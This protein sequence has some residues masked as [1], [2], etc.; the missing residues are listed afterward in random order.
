VETVES[1]RNVLAGCMHERIVQVSLQAQ[2]G[3]KYIWPYGDGETAKRIVGILIPKE[4]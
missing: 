4:E 2:K 3:K 1:G